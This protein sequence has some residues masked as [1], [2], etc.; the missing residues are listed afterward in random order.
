[1]SGEIRRTERDPSI[2]YRE[3]R[4]ADLPS[5]EKVLLF[6]LGTLERATGLDVTTVEQVKVLHR[7]G[8]WILL[9]LLRAVRRAPIRVFVAIKEGRV[10]G[11][12]SLLALK[13]TGYIL[14]VATDPAVRGRGIA[15]RL[16]EQERIVAQHLGKAWLAL[17]VESDNETAIRVY[18]RHGFAEIARFDWFVGTMPP[19]VL[20]PD[21]ALSEL[22]ASHLA[23]LARWADDH[24]PPTIRDPFPSGSRVLSHLELIISSPRTPTRTWNLSP[25]GALAGG[26][27]AFFH[28]VTRTGFLLPLTFDSELSA[29]SLL[30]LLSPGLSWF[31]SLDASKVVVV[32]PQAPAVWGPTLTDLG[33]SKVV[34]STLM[35]RS[36]GT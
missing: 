32:V 5:F 13:K 31:R 10:V 9:R 20:P 29:D 15:T 27:R 19:V 12:A 1:M 26:V 11:T 16:L 18:R 34:S 25:R 4:R 8:I 28:P 2:I 23:E 24:R 22:D 21:P 3:L 33:L 35:S 36:I 6:G 14:G 30:Q 7:R 17:D